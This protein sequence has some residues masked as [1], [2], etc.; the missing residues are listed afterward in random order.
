ML[1]R[2]IIIGGGPQHHTHTTTVIEKR[3]PT[4]ESIRLL[5]EMQSKARDTLITFP[6]SFNGLECHIHMFYDSAANLNNEKVVITYTLNGQRCRVD[7]E[8]SSYDT[9]DYRI[10]KVR[11]VLAQSLASHMLQS[12]VDAERSLGAK[13]LGKNR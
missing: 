6:V 11:D 13:L 12:A 4:D 1:D 7:T 8:F 9:A 2:N 10:K 3:A 5:Q